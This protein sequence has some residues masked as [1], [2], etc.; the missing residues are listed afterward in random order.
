MANAVATSGSTTLYNSV[1][2]YYVPG[3][4]LKTTETS[5]YARSFTMPYNNT[6]YVQSNAAEGGQAIASPTNESS[7]TTSNDYLL[8]IQTSWCPNAINAIEQTIPLPA[9]SYRLTF[10]SYVGTTLSNASSLC[11]ISYGATPTTDYRWPS[12]LNTWTANVIDFELAA[13]TNV[14]FSLGYKKTADQGA[15]NTPVLFVDNLKLTYYTALGIAQ[16]QWQDV[17]DALAALNANVL[18]TAAKNA[19]NTELAKSVPTTSVDDVNNAKDA[20]QALIDSYDDIK[21]AYDKVNEL[22]TLATNEVTYSAGNKTDFSTAISTATT[23]KEER[24]DADDLDDDYDTLESARQTYVT[25]GAEPYADHPF[26]CTF[27]ITNPGFEA[28]GKETNSPTGWTIPNKGAQYGA[29]NRG[30]VSN[31]TGSYMFNNWQS[32]WQDCN[33]EQTIPSLPKGRYEVTAVLASYNGVSAN[34]QAGGGSTDSNMTGENNGIRVS[35]NGDVTGSS[36]TI[37]ARAG[38]KN[39]GSLL[40]ADDFT[41]S[42]IGLKPVLNDLISSA[43]TLSTSNIGTGVF[44]IPSSAATTLTSAIETV[45]GVYDDAS[46]YGDDIQDAIDDLNDA[47]DVFKATELNTPTDGKRYKLTLADRGTLTYQTSST[48]GGYGFP[49]MTSGDHMAQT[50]ILTQV[51]GNNYTI[52]FEDFDGN[53]RYICTRAQYGE[54]GTGTAGIRSFVEGEEGKDALQVT[55]QASSTDNVF[56][57]LNTE[58]DNAKLGSNGGDFYTDNT[59]TSWSISEASQASVP[60]TIADGVNF[61]TRIFPFTPTL[62][63]GV[64]AYSCAAK[65]GEDYLTLSKVDA[66]EANVP[67][68]LYAESGSTGTLTGYGTATADTYTTGWLT[69]VYT[70]TLVPVNSYVLQNNKSDGVAFYKVAEGEQP[71]ANPYRCY[72]TD[73]G[74]GGARALYF[75]F[76]ETNA[77]ETI[78]ALTAGKNTIYNAAGKVVPSLQKG[79]NI[80]KMSDG[81]IRKVMVK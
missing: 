8:A 72:L 22:I 29:K 2:A 19:I 80:I 28:D 42:F 4:E 38:R 12:T 40:R 57:M 43:T 54:G 77:V 49:F 73:G 53:T 26:E 20:L 55:I 41:L 67:Y 58:R 71:T 15:G 17:H 16:A 60:V 1:N 64:I 35:V 75:N 21:T 31:M 24:T 45:Q 69:G 81:S 48:E 63:S 70:P 14:T 36:L 5:D 76:D 56:Y 23:N 47:I 27:K 18:P 9:G 37:R 61:A 10:D 59:Y 52:C 25:S 3:W 44:Q 68:I 78:K 7:V 30:S 66:P 6:L 33:V 50:F 34:L 39:D 62:P 74:V 46:K 79:L 13:Q 51:S 32:W 11:G 65:D